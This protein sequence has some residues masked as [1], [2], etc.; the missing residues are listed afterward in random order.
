MFKDIR[1]VT[2]EQGRVLI[3]ICFAGWRDSGS[4]SVPQVMLFVV[5]SSVSMQ[6]GN[7]VLQP[8]ALLIGCILRLLSPALGHRTEMMLKRYPT[9]LRTGCVHDCKQAQKIANMIANNIEVI[10]FQQGWDC[11]R[12]TNLFRASLGQQ[13]LRPSCHH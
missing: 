2:P 3:C 12:P 6:Y 4:V 9:R 8:E 13:W 11:I 1:Y 10:D 5:L 7:P